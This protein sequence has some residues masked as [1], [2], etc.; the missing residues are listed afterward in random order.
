[1]AKPETSTHT[2][3]HLILLRALCEN[4]MGVGVDAV[5]RDLACFVDHSLS[6][7]QRRKRCD[8]ELSGLVRA[9]LLLPGVRKT[10]AAGPGG[11]EAV[12]LFLGQKIKGR[13]VWERLKNRD[14]IARSLGMAKAGKAQ[15][16][17]LEKIGGLRHA[18]VQ[19]E[20][21]L[22]AKPS[23]SAASLRNQLAGLALE[24]G[25]G[26][27]F[28]NIA[29]GRLKL[30]G[31]TGRLIAAQ[32]LSRPRDFPNDN[33]LIAQI[34]AEKA[35]ATGTGLAALRDAVLRKLMDA[36]LEDID[37]ARSDFSSDLKGFSV[38]VHTMAKESAKG[39]P[40]NRRAYISHVWKSIRSERPEL[41]LN[42]GRFKTLLA[43]AHRAGHVNLL[44]ADLR[45]RKNMADLKA[46]VVNYKNTEWHFIR[47]DD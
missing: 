22:P 12:E 30:P 19:S 20:Y 1:M 38:V 32:L 9:G 16:R 29:K 10:V 28:K 7:A 27:K 35:G 33:L 8:D 4:G 41:G 40:G 23:Q 21:G 2:I 42:E 3:R 18:I 11:L 47:V 25:F 45:N 17:A 15:T 5:R 34:A 37:Q 26:A 46:S 44:N 6:P 31:P 13:P 43:E 39:W 14:L 36:P 24:Q